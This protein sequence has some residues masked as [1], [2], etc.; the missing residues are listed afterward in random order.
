MVVMM[1]TLVVNADGDG[2]A[3]M[4]AMEPAGAGVQLQDQKPR[5][6]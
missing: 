1:L 3:A 5:S 6:Y 4:T 2:D